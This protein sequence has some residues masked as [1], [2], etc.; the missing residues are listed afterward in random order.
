[1]TIEVKDVQNVYV[2][3]DSVEFLELLGSDFAA[4]F[5]A[6][7]FNYKRLAGAK[8]LKINGQDAYDY[9]DY[10]ARTQSGMSP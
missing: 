2:A 3:P 6:L 10:V 7:G 5:S 9:V 4:Y 8:V 1:V